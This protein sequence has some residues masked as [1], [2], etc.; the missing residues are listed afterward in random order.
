M[1]NTSLEAKDY[2]CLVSSVRA[3]HLDNEAQT[4][5]IRIA[6]SDHQRTLVLN[7]FVRKG[8]EE[9]EEVGVY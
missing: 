3:L 2:L 6:N 4:E 5:K 7:I 8:K 9:R 1:T